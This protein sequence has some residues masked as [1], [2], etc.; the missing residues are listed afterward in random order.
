MKKLT[1][2][3]TVSVLSLMVLFSGVSS[4]AENVPPGGHTGSAVSSAPPV[5]YGQI[6]FK[7]CTNKK[8]NLLVYLQR[9]VGGKWKN[10]GHTGYS[11]NGCGDLYF[12]TEY[13]KSPLIRKFAAYRVLVV[14]KSSSTV[15]IDIKTYFK[16][17]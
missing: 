14:N 13:G 3:F 11:P 5:E 10:V 8:A 1:K 12:G 17:P 6:K 2:L 9:K 7:I 4:A 16:A 15:K